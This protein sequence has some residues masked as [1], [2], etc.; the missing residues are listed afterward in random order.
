MNE[1][2]L[3]ITLIKNGIF[4]KMNG[5]LIFNTEQEAKDLITR[6]ENIYLPVG[7]ITTRYADVLTNQ[8]NDKFAV[9]IIEMVYDSLSEDERNSLVDS[10]PVD[11]YP[12]SEFI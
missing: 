3:P 1:P 4:T 7:Q 12:E 10:L 2:K 9:R 6:L 5:Y 11:W 8:H